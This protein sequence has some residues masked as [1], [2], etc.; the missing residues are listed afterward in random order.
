MKSRSFQAPVFMFVL[1]LAACAGS[2][3]GPSAILDAG[4]DGRDNSSVEA[5]GPIGV[6]LS[7]TVKDKAGMV[8]QGAKI[9]SGMASAL[10]DAQGKYDLRLVSGGDVAL[11][12]TRSW[13]K[14]LTAMVAVAASGTTSYDI[15]VEEIPLKLDPDDV[16]LTET[17]AKTFDWARQTL[18][19]TIAAKAT[20]RDFDNAVYFR[21][22]AL[23][24]DTSKEVAVTPNPLP[25]LEGGKPLNLSFV[26]RSGTNQ[27]QEA[28]DIASVVDSLTDT[29][30]V[31][32]DRNGFFTWNPMVT[33]LSDW[34]MVKA[35]DLNAA[36]VAVRQQ[37]WG[38][39]APRPQ[40]I[41]RAFI[42]NTSGT[43]WV[44]IVFATFV[45]T[46]PGISDNDGD[47]RKE[48][49][50]KLATVHYGK[51][52]VAQLVGDYRGRQFGTHALSRE[53]SK[54]LN[55]LYSTTAAQVERLIG[56]PFDVPGV[57]TIKYPFVVLRHA[58]GQKNVILVGP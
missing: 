37:N 18:S 36:G 8:V 26:L 25:S 39:N 53:V 5:T 44:E 52:L 32:A 13:F 20:R 17:Y 3:D 45:Q 57:G 11:K 4:A 43:M 14:P 56:D 40:E 51:D 30:L 55:A 6:G 34:D 28:L 50:A 10:T 42:D 35:A 7:G 16:A 12:V 31:P 58:G 27:G 41:E 19:I 24:R 48:I 29:M 46:G 54:S 47:G 2:S 49:Y 21:N 22:P 9:E 15:V 38:A 23:Y 1:A 33:W